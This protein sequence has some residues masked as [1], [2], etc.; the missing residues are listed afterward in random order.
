MVMNGGLRNVPEG[1]LTSE[2]GRSIRTLVTFH[3]SR[4]V[5]G[6]K[7]PRKLPD[8]KIRGWSHEESMSPG[9]PGAFSRL[10]GFTGAVGAV[11]PRHDFGLCQRPVRGDGSERQSSVQN[12]SGV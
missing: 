11:R 3:V 5:D 2:A 9:G 8:L 7:I 6:S 4:R 1:R 10:S 12:Q